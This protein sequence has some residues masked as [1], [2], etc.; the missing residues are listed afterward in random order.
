MAEELT[1][2]SPLCIYVCVCLYGVYV[3]VY[4]SIVCASMEIGFTNLVYGPLLVYL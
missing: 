4:P 2:T 3:H 1:F